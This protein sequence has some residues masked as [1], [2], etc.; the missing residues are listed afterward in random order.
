MNLR[1]T[2]AWEESEGGKRR[3]E[4]M[5]LYFNFK[6]KKNLTIEGEIAF[7]GLNLTFQVQC[8]CRVQTGNHTGK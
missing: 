2:R 8:R 5:W 6:K 4:M 7:K 1:G 3:E